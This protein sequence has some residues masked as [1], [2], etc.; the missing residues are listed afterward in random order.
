MS[1]TLPFFQ[2]FEG[3]VK[4]LKEVSHGSLLIEN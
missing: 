3:Q 4:I 1:L 2:V